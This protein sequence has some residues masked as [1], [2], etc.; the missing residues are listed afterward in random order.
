MTDGL[1]RPVAA[2]RDWRNTAIVGGRDEDDGLLGLAYLE[3]ADVLADHWRAH[4]PDDFLALPILFNYRHGL[5]LGLKSAV[6]H[7]AHCARRDG[8]EDPRLAREALDEWL[9]GTHSIGQLVDRL[10]LAFGLLDLPDE[11][12]MPEG[13]RDVLAALHILDGSGQWFRYSSIKAVAPGERKKTL[14]P[15]RPAEEKFDLDAVA[16]A[17][18][19]ALVIIVH[20]VPS[21]LEQ[22]ED[23]RM[24]LR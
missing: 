24:D 1:L 14:V 11:M 13:T 7:A 8:H 16:E 23:W 17:L 10:D 2:A 9:S 5:E 19:D 20:G 6:R 18:H 4:R 22:Y 12:G 21:V 3:A 15:A